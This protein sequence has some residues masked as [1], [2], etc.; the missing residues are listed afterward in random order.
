MFDT[1]SMSKKRSKAGDEI[2]GARRRRSILSVISTLVMLGSIILVGAPANAM[3]TSN[4]CSFAVFIGVRGTGAAAGTNLTHNGRVWTTG[5]HGTQVAPVVTGLY[6]L[7]DMPFY[8]ESLAYPALPTLGPSIQDGVAKLTAELNYVAQTCP[9]S[10]IV[11][12]G[13]SQ[14]AAVITQTLTTSLLLSATAKANIRNVVLYGD[15]YYQRGLIT[16]YPDR[17]NNGALW[18]PMVQNKVRLADYKYWGWPAGGNSEAW[19]YKVREYCNI[20]DYFCQN[21]TADSGFVIH[22]SYAQY[23]NSVTG[24]IQYSMTDAN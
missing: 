10:P 9:Y 21:N 22:N 24:W 3:P 8:F 2:L 17:A 4:L 12:A 7:P 5:G 19:I 20:G 23:A 13:H 14:G 15:P 11:L 18:D 6:N 16:N 1:R